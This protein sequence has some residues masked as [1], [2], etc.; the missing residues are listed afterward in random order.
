M[1]GTLSRENCIM[2]A[3]NDAQMAV[4]AGICDYAYITPSDPVPRDLRYLQGHIDERFH[5]HGHNF[6]A[7]VV[8]LKPD[9]I[10][11]AFRGTWRIWTD[12]DTDLNLASDTVLFVA[13]RSEKD[14]RKLANKLH[15]TLPFWIGKEGNGLFGYVQEV[16]KAYPNHRVIFAGHSLGGA[17]AKLCALKYDRQAITFNAFSIVLTQKRHFPDKSNYFLLSNI[18]AHR[19]I[20]SCLVKHDERDQKCA[21]EKATYR[22][23]HYDFALGDIVPLIRGIFTHGMTRFREALEEKADHALRKIH[24][25]KPRFLN[26]WRTYSSAPLG[27]PSAV[28]ACGSLVRADREFRESIAAVQSAGLFSSTGAGGVVTTQPDPSG[29]QPS[30]KRA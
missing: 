20:V 2:D 4:M 7:I 18:R 15:N 10:V 11:I 30:A 29:S 14:A 1:S 26:F 19:D 25:P 28:S 21:G 13:T 3:A 24:V 5:K 12:I 23:I 27:A 17:L 6:T 16:F 22:S 8:R 9:C